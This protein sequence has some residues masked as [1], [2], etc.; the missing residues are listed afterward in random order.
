VDPETLALFPLW[1]A[2]FLL[3]LTFHEAAHAWAAHRGGDDTAYLAGQVSLSPWPH[4]RRE[5]LGTILAPILTYWQAHWMMGWASA[6][7][8]P[9]WEERHPHR[10]AAMAAAG[11][12]ANL[13]L[14]AVA[15]AVLKIGMLSGIWIPAAPGQLGLDRLVAAA[16]DAAGW[17]DAAGRFM[18]VLFVLNL[19]L[20]VFNLLPVPPLD[21]ISVLSGLVPPLRNLYMKMRGTPGL[22]LVGLIVAWQVSPHVVRPVLGAA[23]RALLRH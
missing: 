1:Y 7:Y 5:P 3:S 10:A 14:F 18:S 2:A 12:A 15:F 23:V 4:I 6:P 9:Y 13:L 19:I 22:T 17:V 21:G 16:P 20:G 11:P 8:D